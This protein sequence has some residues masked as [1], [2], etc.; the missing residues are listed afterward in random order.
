MLTSK[1]ILRLLGGIWVLGVGAPDAPDPNIDP[2]V[3]WA[4]AAAAPRPADSPDS[5]PPSAKPPQKVPVPDPIGA[6]VRVVDLRTGAHGSGVCV[7]T[8]DRKLSLV[9]TNN[10]L[11]A[12]PAV[13][14]ALVATPVATRTQIIDRQ[15]QRWPAWVMGSCENLDLAFLVVSTELPVAPLAAEDAQ[16]DAAVWHVGFGSGGGKGVVLRRL[17]ERFAS[18]TPSVGGDSG[19]G[20]FNSENEVVAINCGRC[21]FAAGRPEPAGNPQRGVPVSLVRAALEIRLSQSYPRLVEA[22]L[23]A[24]PPRIGQTG[25]PATTTS[26]PSCRKYATTPAAEA[27]APAPTPKGPTPIPGGR[28]S[29]DLRPAVPGQIGGVWLVPALRDADCRV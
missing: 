16:P 7:A 14:G 27:P 24:R 15:G 29:H 28:S 3:V 23:D 21:G 6:T 1:A 9:I 5:P 18:T 12:P 4:W 19:A 13:G 17:R 20:I 25:D 26:C 10:H 22:A 2:E 11:V 8:I